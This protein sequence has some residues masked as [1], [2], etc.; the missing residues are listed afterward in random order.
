MDLTAGFDINLLVGAKFSAEDRFV[1]TPID[2]VGSRYFARNGVGRTCV[3]VS[4][5]LERNDH[6][7][8]RRVG[9]GML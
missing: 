4:E 5:R 9:C 7:G 6:V 2:S 3:D 8:N 1:L